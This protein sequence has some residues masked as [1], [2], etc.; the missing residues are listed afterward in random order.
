MRSHGAY[1]LRGINARDA[2]GGGDVIGGERRSDQLTMGRL[3]ESSGEAPATLTGPR[4]RVALMRHA[5]GT[6]NLRGTSGDRQYYAA[7]FQRDLEI[8]C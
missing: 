2:R 4:P 8:T 1:L 3:T 6:G 7:L 5:R